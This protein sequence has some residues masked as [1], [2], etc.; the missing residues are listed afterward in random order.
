M[1]F[2]GGPIVVTDRSFVDSLIKLKNSGETHVALCLARS[3]STPVSKID[4]VFSIGKISNSYFFLTFRNFKI[5]IIFFLGVLAMIEVVD[6]KDPKSQEVVLTG[7]HRIIISLSNNPKPIA[8]E[9]PSASY[10]KVAVK[11][12]K[13]TCYYYILQKD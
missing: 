3:S 5:F 2:Y 7:T 4:D 10:F 6:T 9:N 1:A 13:V 11:E 12:L 8:A